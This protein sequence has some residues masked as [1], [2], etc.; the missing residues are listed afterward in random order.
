MNILNSLTLFNRKNKKE[1]FFGVSRIRAFLPQFVMK[2]HVCCICY[3]LYFFKIFTFNNKQLCVKKNT[4]VN[5]FNLFISVKIL[6][7]LFISTFYLFCFWKPLFY[8][9]KQACRTL[10]ISFLFSYFYLFKQHL[11]SNLFLFDF[12]ILYI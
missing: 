9:S 8:L 10:F 6:Y 12:C 7:Y 11:F 2:M 3:F 1:V 4:R 5:K